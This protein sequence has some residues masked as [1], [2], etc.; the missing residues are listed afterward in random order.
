MKYRDHKDVL[1]DKM[2]RY[3]TQSLFREFYLQN[4]SCPPLWCLKEEDPQG[5]LPS[6]KALYME[7][8]DPT[9][10]EFAMQAFGSWEHWLKIKSVKIIKPYIEDWPTEL[11]VKLRS[12]AI[13]TIINETKTGKTPFNAA[14]FLA[15]G[16]WKNSASKR[17][18]PS[19]EEVDRERKIAAKLDAE[20]GEDA[21]RLGLRLIKN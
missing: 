2:N 21:A 14:K 7:C 18:R 1:K 20:I 17:G 15:K 9:E 10:Y 12:E 11:E 13:Q 16:E 4:E 3:R 8:A 5:T 19:K 6:L